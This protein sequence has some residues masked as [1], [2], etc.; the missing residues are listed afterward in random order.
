MSQLP[1][2]AL[3]KTSMQVSRLGFGSMG[4][5][6]PKTWG[7]R[8]VDDTTA[9]R[10]LNAALDAG[11]NFIDTSPDYGIAEQRIGN[12]LSHRRHEYFLATKCGCDPIQHADHLEIRHTWTI[13]TVKANL[14]ESLKRLNTDYLDLL[15]FHGGD[16]E[17]LH[18]RGLTQ[19]LQDLRDEGTVKH[20]GVSSKLPQ[21][22]QHLA[23]GVFDVIQVPYSCLNIEHADFIREASQRGVGI[24]VRGGI[25]Q[26]GPDAEIQREALNSV[27]QAAQLAELLP[28]GMLPAELILRFTLSDPNCHT[29]IVGTGSLEHLQQ[30]VEAARRGPLDT[31]L[32]AEIRRRVAA[33]NI[34]LKN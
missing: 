11:I 14:A 6:G 26:G 34:N 15:Q 7:V 8:V 20:I 1:K 18:E 10:V 9:E 27:W 33:A 16:S 25:A 32:V 21:A 3:G 29:T 30:N 4:L 19:L 12:F 23:S 28:S 22:K 5:R 17:T 31:N 24:I 2:I 13:D